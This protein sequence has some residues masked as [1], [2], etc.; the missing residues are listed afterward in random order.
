[1]KEDK[2][3]KPLYAKNAAELALVPIS[4]HNEDALRKEKSIQRLSDLAVH[5]EFCSLNSHGTVK[6]LLHDPQSSADGD[7]L[8]IKSLHSL[9]FLRFHSVQL[10]S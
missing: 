7:D 6:P 2:R 9:L 1:M 10:G 3:L 8:F 5:R 4:I